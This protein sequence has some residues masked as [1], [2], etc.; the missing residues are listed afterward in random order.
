ME[1][2]RA[3]LKAQRWLG[4]ALLAQ[5]IVLFF[6]WDGFFKEPG[7]YVY[8]NFYDG[9]RQYY[10]FQAYAEQTP[11]QSWLKVESMG[12]PYG[13]YLLYTDG[14]P[15]LAFT[16]RF[17]ST[18]L[19][20]LSGHET[21]AFNFFIM[22]GRLFSTVLVF[23]ILRRLGVRAVLCLLFAVALPWTNGEIIKLAGGHI[24][25]SF[26]WPLLLAIY[27]FLRLYQAH[28]KGK[29]DWTWAIV[30]A[31]LISL[32][33]FL[34][35][36]W[37]PLS[38]FVLGFSLL[39]YLIYAWQT[40]QNWQP[41]VGYG[42]ISTASPWVVV[43]GLIRL[44][45]GYF[46]HRV[47]Q[48][49]GYGWERWVFELSGYYSSHPWNSVRFILEDREI[50]SYGSHAYL[51]NF[52]LFFAV[53]LLIFWWVNKRYSFPVWGK[54]QEQKE[55]QF[56]LLLM[57][58]VLV[59]VFISLGENIPIWDNKYVIRNYLNIFYYLRKFTDRI[60]QF[61][62][63]SRFGMIGFWWVNLA[64][65]YLFDRYLKEKD[66]TRVR[67]IGLGLLVLLALD[68]KDAWRNS[69]KWHRDNLLYN[70]DQSDIDELIAG[71]NPDEYQAA[72]PIPYF[73]EGVGD[74]HYAVD[75]FDDAITHTM[76]LQR[77]T[78]LPLI[79]S[80]FARGNKEHGLQLISL[81][82]G[83]SLG[84]GISPELL[85]QLD[86]RPILLL[87]DE[88]YYDGTKQLTGNQRQP[89]WDLLNHAHEI[90]GKYGMEE[91][92]RY[93]H[94][95]LYRWEIAPIRA[96]VLQQTNADKGDS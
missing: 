22:L 49:E 74:A 59:S 29:P 26:S 87:Y 51:G 73:H 37:L 3:V 25:L 18:Y 70:Q 24:N 93:G 57:V 58:G 41:I 30:Y 40:Q 34:H 63:V 52:T 77:W 10:F 91:V 67:I 16:V 21:D 50:I 84:V 19:V 42:L 47:P 60:T 89:A 17:I 54:L 2:I 4:L 23:A 15:L 90:I 65:V 85:S 96:A 78:G 1:K 8:C 95:R 31:T 69:H 33:A 80:K 39:A 46:A 6:T 76:Q 68:T 7:R 28:E 72:F 5:C 35:L 75:G 45:D 12:Y 56:F 36:Y 81:L 64:A 43:M 14:T 38:T 44:T 53:V 66:T 9:Q 48:G 11:D 88:L 86:D 79:T 82:Q 32:T 13:E 83:D 94:F 61:R 55:G 71:I 92:A 20:D 27:S 62:D